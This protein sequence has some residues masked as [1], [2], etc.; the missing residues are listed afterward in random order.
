MRH[1][2]SHTTWQWNHG[3][4]CFFLSLLFMYEMNIQASPWVCR[5]WRVSNSNLKPAGREAPM[6]WGG[7]PFMWFWYLFTLTTW[8]PETTRLKYPEGLAPE[9]KSR[10]SHLS[11]R[12]L[13]FR[14]TCS[15]QCSCRWGYNTTFIYNAQVNCQLII[16]RCKRQKAPVSFLPPTGHFLSQSLKHPSNL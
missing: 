1:L 9:N 11:L 13:F 16:Q 6:D 14:F 4:V 7:C 8:Q 2:D 10:P 3:A 15:L 12:P 5:R